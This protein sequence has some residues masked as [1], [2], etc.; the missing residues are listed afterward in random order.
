VLTITE[1]TKAPDFINIFGA[2]RAQAVDFDNKIG[3]FRP[4]EG[5]C[6]LINWAT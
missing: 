5:L 3:V 6:G 2:G 1:T 4:I